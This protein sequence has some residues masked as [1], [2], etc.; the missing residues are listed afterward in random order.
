[1]IEKE[2]HHRFERMESSQA[3]DPHGVLGPR[4]REKQENVL[5]GLRSSFLATLIILQGM[6]S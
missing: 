5:D 4:K 1:M 2:I 6:E 3:S